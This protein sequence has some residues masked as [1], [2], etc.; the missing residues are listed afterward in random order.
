MNNHISIKRAIL[1][2]KEY[3]VI[4]DEQSYIYGKDGHV[5]PL[6]DTVYKEVE[7]DK[8]TGIKSIRH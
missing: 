3:K 7:I 5:G 4:V 8:S 2:N 6:D 1:L